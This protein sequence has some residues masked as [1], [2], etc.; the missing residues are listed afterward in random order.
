MHSGR[1]KKSGRKWCVFKILVFGYAHSLV[2]ESSGWGG[3]FQRPMGSILASQ[4]KQKETHSFCSLCLLPF[5]FPPPVTVVSPRRE[6]LVFP[7]ATL[8]RLHSLP[9]PS[10]SSARK[11][12]QACYLTR[13]PHSLPSLPLPP[14]QPPSPSLCHLLSSPIQTLSDAQ[15]DG[16][17]ACPGT[18]CRSAFLLHNGCLIS[19]KSKGKVKTSNSCHCDADP[20]LHFLTLQPKYTMASAAMFLT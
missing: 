15:I 16:C 4:S 19:C 2:G 14:A 3:G 7:S 8:A 12:M 20:E 5:P 13:L 11:V 1:K 17:L 10:M 9:S 18:R 6:Q